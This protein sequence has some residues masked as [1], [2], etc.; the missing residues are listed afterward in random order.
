[1]PQ[2]PVLNVRGTAKGSKEAAGAAGK[3]VKLAK[4]ASVNGSG[5]ASGSGAAESKQVG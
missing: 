4:S 2:P 5:S 3:S 1:M